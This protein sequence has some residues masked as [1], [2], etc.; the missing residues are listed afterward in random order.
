MVKPDHRDPGK[1][2]EETATSIR[3]LIQDLENREMQGAVVTAAEI[4]KI[5][6]K[7][8]AHV[9]VLLAASNSLRSV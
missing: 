6:G 2:L 5:A 8:Q 3:N 4:R 1:V 9:E 7:L